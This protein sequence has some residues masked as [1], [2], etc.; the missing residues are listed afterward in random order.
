M[1][2]AYWRSG[3]ERSAAQTLEAAVQRTPQHGALHYALALS[4]IRSKQ[5][6]AALESL[7]RS[8][9]YAPESGQY[10]Y[11]YAVALD[12]LG[13]PQEAR[14]FLIQAIQKRPDDSTLIALARS[15][16]MIR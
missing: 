8:V 3:D 5:Y 9:A 10:I 12:Q 11:T 1:A 4:Q 14:Q 2:E 15:W 7:R 16:G 6:P 13:K